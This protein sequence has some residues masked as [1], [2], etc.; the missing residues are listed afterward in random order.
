MVLALS[1]L[2]MPQA[3]GGGPPAQRVVE[4]F[5]VALAIG[6]SVSR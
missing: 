1:I 2:P 3:W 5:D 6:P 4:G